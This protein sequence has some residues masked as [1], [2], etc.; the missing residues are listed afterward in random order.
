MSLLVTVQQLVSAVSGEMILA[1]GISSLRPTSKY[2]QILVACGVDH[3]ELVPKLPLGNSNN[4]STRDDPG[5]TKH[6][7]FASLSGYYTRP[8]DSDQR[9]M[10]VTNILY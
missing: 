7:C 6:S 9:G 2:D 5:S 8:T 4:S 10:F 3:L 1:V